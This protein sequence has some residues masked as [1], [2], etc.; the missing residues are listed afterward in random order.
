M[1]QISNKLKERGLKPW[2][3]EEQIPPGRSFQQAIPTVK[4]ATITLGADGVG[5]CQEWEIQVFFSQGVRRGTT[6]IPVLL[7]GVSK[8]PDS[9][10]F[11][12]Q[13]RWINFSDTEDATDLGLM[14]WGITG[15]RP[16]E[17]LRDSSPSTTSTEMMQLSSFDADACYS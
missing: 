13:L 11:L 10:P 17:E 3:D 4:T 12:Q 5:S 1:H 15:E 16:Q 9:L 8:V 7:S 14:I 6:V 2:I